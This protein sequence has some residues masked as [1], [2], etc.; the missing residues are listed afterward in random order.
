MAVATIEPFVRTPHTALTMNPSSRHIPTPLLVALLLLAPACSQSA[1]RADGVDGGAALADASAASAD[2]NFTLADGSAPGDAHATLA[3]A[4]AGLADASP[5]PDAEPELPLCTV[6]GPAIVTDID[7]TLTT[8]DGE[9]LL[10]MLV[11]THEPAER[12]GA[13]ALVT[14]FAERGYYVLYLTARPGDF[15][16]PFTFEPSPDATARWLEEH[17][18]PVDPERTRLSLA[19]TTILDSATT[20]DY[21][22]G[23][24]A[25]LQ[26]EGFD[27]VYAYGNAATDIAAY[28]A[29]GI[30]KE[31]TFIIGPEAGTEATVAIAGDGWVDHVAEFLPT[32][33]AVCLP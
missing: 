21:K 12:P 20:I 30:A 27:I 17:G 26:A 24:L 29:V 4:G 8:G 10:Q 15:Y 16:L 32:V 6:P 13:A 2:A 28:E 31:H 1:A 18:Y 22:S 3:D 23:V 19:P 14:A 25:N 33:D 11:G 7:A 5:L 9:W